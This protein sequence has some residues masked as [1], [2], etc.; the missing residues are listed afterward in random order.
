MLLALSLN[1]GA[2]EDTLNAAMRALN[3]ELP[4]DYRAFLGTSNGGEGFLGEN[5]VSLWKAEELEPNNSGYNVASFAP[6]LLLFGSDGGGEAYAFDTRDNP[7]AVVKVP[8]IGMGEAGLAIPL[9][10]SF[11]EFLKNISL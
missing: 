6:G 4:H 11:T 2:S 5:Y 3:V 7:W 8:F 1:P 9:G 10:H